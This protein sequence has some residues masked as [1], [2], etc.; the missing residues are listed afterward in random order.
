[1]KYRNA[2]PAL[3]FIGSFVL[4][5]AFGPRAEAAT[6][7]HFVATNGNDSWSGRLAAPNA[8]RTDGPFATIQKAQ[9]AVR[10]AVSAGMTGNVIVYLRAGTYTL[11]SPLSFTSADSGSGSYTIT[12]S[13]YPGESAIISGG[14]SVTGWTLYNSSNNIYRASVGAGWDFRELYVNGTHVT[15]ASSALNPPGW[16]LTPTGFTAPNS[17]MAAWGNISN[18]EIVMDGHWMMNRC[19][20]SSISGTTVTMQQPCFDNFNAFATKWGASTP[21]WIENAYELL[22]PGEWYLDTAAGYVYY[23]PASGQTMSS[24]MVIAPKLQTLI[25]ASGLSNVIFSN[26][27]FEYTTWLGPDQSGNGYV[28]S[29]SGY[30]WTGSSRSSQHP[31]WSPITFE[32]SSYITFK[33][34]LFSHLGGRALFFD[35]GN[36]NIDVLANKFIDNAAGAVQFG[37]DNNPST[38]NTALQSLNATIRNNYLTDGF[39]YTDTSTVFVPYAAGVVIDHNQFA[40]SRSVPIA[41]GWGW[42]T[43]SYSQ[44]NQVTWNYISNFCQNYTDCGAI[45]TL[46][47]EPGFIASNNYMTGGGEGYG[48]VYP[49]EGSAN[50]TWTSNVC[51][52]VSSTWLH[53]WTSSITGNSITGNWTS[54]GNMVDKGSNNTVSGNTVVSN[55]QWPS[56]AE[57]VIRGAGIIAGVTPGPS[58]S[59]SSTPPPAPTASPPA[60][61][62]LTRANPRR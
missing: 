13:S 60:H 30:N 34:D 58:G 42:G 49:D 52:E 46:S 53:I 4:M 20:V 55:G 1:M 47:A 19:K 18:I 62:R 61:H 28:D 26:L 8:A 31:M 57:T 24:A 50:E 59:S 41:I 35:S 17:T 15:R 12:W 56:G 9:I 21:S 54:N 38:T 3:L 37:N 51:N 48:C 6:T 2:L 14:A 36:K 25:S 44:N 40:G 39:E 23:V 27:S 45:Y 43:N 10:A 22:S 5:M 33:N 32:S 29:Q 16:T 11:A 7:T